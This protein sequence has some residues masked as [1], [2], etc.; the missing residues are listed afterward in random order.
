MAGVSRRQ[1]QNF[2]FF[3]KNVKSLEFHEQIWNHHEKCIQISTNMPDF[4]SLIREIDVK[5][6][7]I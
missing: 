6:S 4:G 1:L 3:K 2:I 5:I 7:E